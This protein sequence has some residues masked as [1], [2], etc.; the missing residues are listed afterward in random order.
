MVLGSRRASPQPPV[1]YRLATPW[2]CAHYE[3][4]ALSPGPRHPQFAEGEI[5]LG[6]G[7][8]RWRV[9]PALEHQLGGVVVAEHRVLTQQLFT[10]ADFGQNGGVD[11]LTVQRLLPR[12]LGV[13]EPSA[14]RHCRIPRHAK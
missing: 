14:G 11:G 10:V 9:M 1:L 3:R 13:A 12:N 4:P 5:R 7:D 6:D 2:S 8:C